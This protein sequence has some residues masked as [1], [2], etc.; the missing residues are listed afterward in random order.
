MTKTVPMVR[1][2]NDTVNF[3][4]RIAEYPVCVICTGAATC[5]NTGGLTIAKRRSSREDHPPGRHR[6]P[7]KFVVSTCRTSCL[8][9]R[10]H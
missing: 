3:G 1:T 6:R 2:D 8:S 5:R 10:Q 7:P 4:S 9:S